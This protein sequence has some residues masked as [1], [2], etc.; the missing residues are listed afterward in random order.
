MSSSYVQ[1]LTPNFKSR[2]SDNYFLW[3]DTDPY[4][5]ADTSIGYDVDGAKI[6]IGGKV[7]GDYDEFVKPHISSGES[8]I[9]RHFNQ[10]KQ[11]YYHK[12]SS[13]GGKVYNMKDML[14]TDQKAPLSEMIGNGRVGDIDKPV[15]GTFLP[16]T[17]LTIVHDDTETS[18][19]G[20]LEGN[21]INSIFFSPMN[22]KVLQN[23]MRY[24]V[25]Q[26][27]GKVIGEQSTNELYII[28]RSIMLQYANFQSTADTVLE[29]IRRLN[30]K[31]LIYCIDS[32]STNVAQQLKYLEELKTL[33]EPIPRPEYVEHPRN[34]TYD[35]SNLL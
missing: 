1:N 32:V 28:M 9:P 26:K 35:M 17:D 8:V 25:Y 19:K 20:I 29:E 2:S 30:G 18:I 24:G 15:P 6:T 7:Y 14:S 31:V 27:T 11:T 34:L 12:D 16:Q 10:G 22:M 33:P 5:G 13:D 4:K 21:A 23:A 3:D